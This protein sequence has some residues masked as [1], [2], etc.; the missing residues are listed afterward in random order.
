MPGSSYQSDSITEEKEENEEEE[1]RFFIMLFSVVLQSSPLNFS[2][3]NVAG[4]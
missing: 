3:H 2:E 4:L 1:S